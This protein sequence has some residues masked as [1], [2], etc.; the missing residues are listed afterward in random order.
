MN[1][2]F[3]IIIGSI[4]AVAIWWLMDWHDKNSDGE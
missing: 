4:G 3:W 2:L 1:Y